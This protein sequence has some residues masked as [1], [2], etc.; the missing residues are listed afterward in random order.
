[1]LDKLKYTLRPTYDVQ[2]K[3][4]GE[5]PEVGVPAREKYQGESRQQPYA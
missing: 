4:H 3:T 2:C 5:K 1:M